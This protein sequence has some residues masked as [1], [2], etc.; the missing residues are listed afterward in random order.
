M[1]T[2][3]AAAAVTTLLLFA[4]AFAHVAELP[5]KRRLD[6]PHWLVVQQH[7]YIAFGPIGAVV[8]PLAIAFVWA[9]A[10][11]RARRM[12]GGS[13]GRCARS[14]RRSASRSGS[15]SGRRSSRR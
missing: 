1:R 6:G 3:R 4:L 7:L 13:R 5:G 11:L 12:G 10:G 15:S 14:R 8:E 2:L 9:L